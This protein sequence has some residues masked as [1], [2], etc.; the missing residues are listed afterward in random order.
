VAIA[1]VINGRCSACQ[2]TLRPQYFQEVRRGDKLLTCEN[3]GRFLFYNPSVQV[4][5]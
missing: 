2:I 3:C 4:A 1:E 5:M